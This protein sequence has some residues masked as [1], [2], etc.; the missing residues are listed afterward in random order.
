MIFI[1][2]GT[3]TSISTRVS[4]YYYYYYYYYYYLELR[5]NTYLIFVLKFN[6]FLHSTLVIYLRFK[7]DLNMVLRAFA[8]ATN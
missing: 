7:E 6:K 4:V 2:T 3:A 1:F 5:N 8:K